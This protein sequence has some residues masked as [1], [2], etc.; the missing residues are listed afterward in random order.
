MDDTTLELAKKILA[1]EARTG[2]EV[3]ECVTLASALI[4]VWDALGKI[5]DQK[6]ALRAAL[7]QAQAERDAATRRAEQAER[8]IAAANA[9]RDAVLARAS[10]SIGCAGC[11]DGVECE[12]GR[13]LWTAEAKAE[14]DLFAALDVPEGGE[15]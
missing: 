12:I 14:F 13:R 11:M 8:V 3:A 4:E 10:H 6:A 1:D 7:A 5:G 15:R 2:T 9:L